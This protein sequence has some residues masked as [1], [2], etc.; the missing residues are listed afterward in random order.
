MITPAFD[1]TQDPDFLTITI[2]VP[3]ARVSEF[4]LYIDGE[5]LKFYAKPYFLRLTLPGRIVEDGRQKA[6]YNADDG[7]FTLQ[8]SKET[9]GQQFEGL[10]L[11]T[12]LLAPKGA[13]T[14]KP[15]IE[16]MGSASEA[17]EE[18]EEEFDWQIE[19]TPFEEASS[20]ALHSHCGYGFGNL[21]A[22]V[23]GRL[24]EELND[25]ID[26][27]DPDVTPASERT[28]RRLAAEKA[29][30]D[31]DHY[32][33]DLFED[34]A[35]QHLLKYKPWWVQ[36][37]KEA[38][39]TSP[40]SQDPRV[41]FTEKEKERLRKFTNKSYL[42]EKKAE[43]LAYLGLIDL[44]LA[45]CYE[46]RVTEGERNVESAWTVRKLSGTLSWFENYRLVT[47]VLV[48]FGR[49]V[50]C[51]PLY[52][53][54]CLVTQAVQDTCALLQMGK[55]AVLKCL[56]D[57]HAIFQENDPAYIL[58]DLYITDY[59]IWIQKVRSKK[60]AGLSD[61][62][63]ATTI[64]KADLGL[65]LEELEEAA[66]LVQEEEKLLQASDH[67][68]R[69]P[70]ALITSEA[71]SSSDSSETEY[72]SSDAEDESDGSS[73]EMELRDSS[74]AL[75]GE[76]GAPLIQVIESAEDSSASLRGEL[77]APLIQVIES[78]ED[79]SASL[80]G[81]LAAPLIQVIE[82]AE[83]SSAALRGEPA[84]P[85]IQVIESAEDSSAALRGELAAPLIQVIE[86]AED[87]SAAL[88]GE[89]AAPLIQVIESAEDS[90]AALRG[91]L[92]APLI[93]VI[94][95]A[96]DLSA[97]LRGEPAAPLIQVIESAED[98]Q[99]SESDPDLTSA[100]LPAP[101]WTEEQLQEATTTLDG[102]IRHHHSATGTP[103]K[104]Q[105][106]KAPD[107]RAQRH[108]PSSETA[109]HTRD[110]VEEAPRLIDRLHI[111][112][113]PAEDQGDDKLLPVG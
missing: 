76:P 17:P 57:V 44:L 50:L 19:Q 88:W 106:Q 103:D 32:L 41:I 12:S 70:A 98:L 108:V 91:E 7:I 113:E 78:A 90:S 89:L 15:L 46:V 92:A 2:K 60:L 104:S 86:S 71:S 109:Q 42:L 25:V 72:S 36:A 100:S 31:P 21:R 84:A 85:L 66:T 105:D 49:R 82:S 23:F 63:Q 43:H 10:N 28:H 34:D 24:Q 33:A 102:P 56:L 97:V 51:Y 99:D 95:S 6:T 87:S 83:D 18:D 58:N 40:D 62:L 68:P 112:G 96:E 77:A 22:G 35:V 75:R 1:I 4:D 30:F 45:Y 39:G 73:E 80:R 9:P 65:E 11:L 52:R 74:A 53:N 14:C 61:C 110:I 3:Y 13:R 16:E 55:A 93:Q 111:V 81:E 8:V 64:S 101:M 26:L 94:E 38:S 27:R 54:F 5:D 47:D 37:A 69:Q 29:K 107:S 20:D 67:V 79:S 59:C 48:S